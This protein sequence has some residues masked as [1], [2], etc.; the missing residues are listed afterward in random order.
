LI[1]FAAALTIGSSV[2]DPAGIVID[3]RITP[4]R[5]P[6]NAPDVPEAFAW[7]V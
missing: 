1:S 6:F 5:I 2:F 4:S 3:S 7:A